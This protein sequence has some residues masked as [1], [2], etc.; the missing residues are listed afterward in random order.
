MPSTFIEIMVLTILI[1]PTAIL[2]AYIINEVG[3]KYFKN[4]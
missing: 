3:N 2:F 4:K 1:I